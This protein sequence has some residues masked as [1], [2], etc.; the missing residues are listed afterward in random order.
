MKQNLAEAQYQQLAK[1]QFCKTI[2]EIPFVSDIEV[3]KVDPQKEFGDF[4]AIVHFTD[5][6]QPMHFWVEV[7]SNGEKRFVNSFMH[8][9]SQYK[10]EGCYVLM[11]PYISEES[12]E[13]MRNKKYSY[14]DLS[15][16]CYILTKRIIIHVSGQVNKYIEKRERKNYLSKSSGAASAIMRTMLDEPEQMWKVKSL[17]QK[18]ER[19]IGTVSN[20]KNF[21]LTKDWIED[22]SQ[23]FKVKNIKEWLHAWAKDYHKKDARSYE[24]YSLDAISDLEQKIA[25]WS[26][27]H[28][29]GAALGGFSAAA[30]YAPT[31]RY[32]KAE[33]Y[34]E[35]QF[36]SEFVR[37]LDLQQVDSGG[38]VVITIPHDETPC[39]F[40]RK[41]NDSLVTSP[42]QTVIDLLGNAGRGEEAAEAIISK[43]YQGGKQ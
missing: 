33:V 34:V 1:E 13:V 35:Q 24:F 37:D 8:T 22:C 19:A 14:M 6:E 38:N 25:E 5:Q 2:N 15:G 28:D 4:R 31:V 7:K 30:R 23:G 27:S 32:K 21:L 43:E 20:V 10:N 29:D 26:L 16:N 42:V 11:A 9:A 18:T 36:L 17:A 12:S 3:M 41:I 39:M 40:C